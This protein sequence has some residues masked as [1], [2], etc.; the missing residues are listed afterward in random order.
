MT[1]HIETSTETGRLVLVRHAHPEVVPG[2]PA[3]DWQL[4]EAGRASCVL[5]ADQLQPEQPQV[6]VTSQ[7][8]KAIQTGALT[9]ARLGITPLQAGDLHEHDRVNVPFTDSA[10]FRAQVRAFFARPDVLIFGGET[11]DAVHDRFARAVDALRQTY[12]GQNL[13]VIAHGTVISLY[14]SRRTGIDPY[15]LWTTLTLPSVVVLDATATR[16]LRR[17]G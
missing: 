4:S 7:E 9:G 11:A 5:L 3:R 1:E 16:I 6:I 13:V 10:T 12:A 17:W 15:T 8:L 2:I 14:V